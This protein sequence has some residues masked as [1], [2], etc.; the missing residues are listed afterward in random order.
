MVSIVARVEKCN[1]GYNFMLSC[2][3]GLILLQMHRLF[4]CL[5]YM[6][7]HADPDSVPTMIPKY[8]IFAPASELKNAK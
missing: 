3:S 8:P 7:I 2:P 5:L 1:D 4:V 6:L